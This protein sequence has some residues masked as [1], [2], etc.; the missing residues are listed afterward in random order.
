MNINFLK[1]IIVEQNPVDLPAH[2]VERD[3]KASIPSLK[4]N[5]FVVV[6]MGVRRCGKSTLLQ[7]IRQSCAEEQSY[8]LNFDDDR[9]ISFQLEDFQ[10]LLECFV[11]LYGEQKT[12]YFDE[13]QNI[14]GWEH[15][16]RRLHN[17]H[18]KVYIT[19]SNATLFSSELGTR[20]TGRYIT[21]EMY[22][23]S[24][25]EFAA[26]KFKPPLTT[27]A[28]GQLKQ[29]FQQ[30]L[31]L[32]GFPEY[33]QTQ[34]TE[35]LHTLYESLLYRDILNRYNLV[36]DRILKELVYYLASN[37]SKEVSYT[38]LKKV[39]GVSS[40]STLSNYCS[41]L[42]NSFLCFFINRF[43]Y[44]LKRQMLFNKKVYFVD[45]V[46]AK[47]I[48][49][50]MSQDRGRLLENVVFMELK[51]RYKEIYFHSQRKECDFLVREQGAIIA[52]YQ[53]CLTLEDEKTWI[54]EK[55]GLIEAMQTYHLSE[56]YILTENEYREEIISHEEISYKVI[57]LPITEWLLNTFAFEL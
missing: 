13:I 15:F 5:P 33:I 57:V 3:A 23:L 9:L 56:G 26:K 19:G 27:I 7:T 32:G 40:T 52:A 34:R 49:F 45:H 8:Y 54:R 42:S 35:Y 53:V 47:Q 6:I 24:F 1:E 12:C 21:L 11:E 31:T 25:S 44:S 17:Q 28:K 39:L 14:P 37:T 50:R 2:Y 16:V 48:G 4:D 20:L 41:Y 46:L 29:Q 18:Y 30:Y 51:R 36:N 22:P 55:D 10:M 43:D 38:T